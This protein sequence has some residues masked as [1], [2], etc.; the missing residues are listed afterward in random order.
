[1]DAQCVVH[2]WHG[3]NDFRTTYNFL[4]RARDVSVRAHG[5][6]MRKFRERLDVL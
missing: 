1:M 3:A 5:E 4:R 6:Q 2:P